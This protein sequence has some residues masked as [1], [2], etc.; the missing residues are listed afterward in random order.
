[1][2]FIKIMS[3]EF[4]VFLF[5]VV[6][7]KDPPSIIGTIKP[8]YTVMEGETVKLWCKVSGTGG[9]PASRTLTAWQKLP[10]VYITNTLA[11]FKMK[12]GKYLRIKNVKLEDQG[13]Y[14]CIAKN[15]YGKIAKE[16]R[17]VVQALN[18][19]SRMSTATSTTYL[20]TRKGS[21]RPQ[22]IPLIDGRPPKFRN[23]S[24][25][26]SE[27]T[28]G[29]PIKLKCHAYGDPPLNVTWVKNG[30]S[31]GKANRRHFKSK[32]WVLHFRRLSLSDTG[33]FIC[34]VRNAFGSIAKTF[35]IKVIEE[36]KVGKQ[37]HEP[38]ILEDGLKNET[39]SP[40]D[41]ATF[42]CSAISKSYP[43]FHFLRWKTSINVSSDSDPFD[44]VDFKKS[45][46]REIREVAKPHT[47][48]RQVY[49]HRLII[50]N[51]TLADE[52]KY[53]CVVGNSAGWVSKHAFLTVQDK[54]YGEDEP[55]G[56]TDNNYTTALTPKNHKAQSDSQILVEKVPLAALVGVPVAVV[57]LLIG[58]IVWCY[59][60]TREHHSRQNWA[61]D[62]KK[63]FPPKQKGCLSPQFCE[64]GKG[65]TRNVS[66]NVYVDCPNEK[67]QSPANEQLSHEKCTLE[68][69]R[70]PPVDGLVI[71]KEPPRTH[72]NRTNHRKKTSKRGT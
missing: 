69:E 2:L 9:P 4:T 30:K 62:H 34:T 28:R 12:L 53:T 7:C 27:Y 24:N 72:S 39:S 60:V 49:T 11:R 56:S 26:S 21:L 50:R 65:E 48:N 20:P 25:R 8:Q 45:K 15:P 51:V 54:E 13:T 37:E 58:T 38:L 41:D 59:F 43:K 23:P 68:F 61:H 14:L 42:V 31:L 35:D 32:S 57:I 10:K 66:F 40:G 70:D 44:F 47:E 19:T 3:L 71:H 55:A 6:Q 22:T 17:L 16:I 64:Q 36:G 29:S 63:Y 18:E 67:I 1:M 52:A 5:A 33:L 46:F